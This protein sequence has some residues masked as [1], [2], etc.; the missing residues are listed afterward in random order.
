MYSVL[1]SIQQSTTNSSAHTSRSGESEPINNSSSV[2]D[3]VERNREYFENLARIYQP[4]TTYM[5]AQIP[6]RCHSEEESTPD[7]KKGKGRAA[8]VAAAAIAKR[9]G[10]LRKLIRR[11]TSPGF[12]QSA[13]M[14]TP[15][16]IIE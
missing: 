10:K 3:S 2:Q 15:P 7:L 6:E 1:I 11:R 14:E 4:D 13:A 9:G 16:S 5:S 8:I 12:F